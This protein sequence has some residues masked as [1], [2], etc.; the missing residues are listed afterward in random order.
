MKKPPYEPRVPK[1][2]QMFWRRIKHKHI[3]VKYP[4]SEMFCYCIKCGYQ[5][6][7]N[8]WRAEDIFPLH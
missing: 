7:Y 3:W 5:G 4:D 6:A 1:Y 2:S 8:E